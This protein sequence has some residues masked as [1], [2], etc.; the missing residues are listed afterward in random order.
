M[1]KNTGPFLTALLLTCLVLS[2]LI[3][4][5]QNASKPMLR[6]R[7]Q[8]LGPGA[9]AAAPSDMD[10][11]AD[12]LEYRGGVM[13]GSGNLVIRRG[14]EVLT[15]DFGTYNAETGDTS[16]RGN[17]HYE[18]PLSGQQFDGDELK[19]NFKTQQWDFGF[20]EIRQ[21]VFTVFSETSEVIEPGLQRFDNAMVTTCDPANPEFY[22]RA[23]EAFVY[24][25]TIVRAKNAVFYLN[26]LPFLYLP[27]YT[28]DMERDTTNFDFLPGYSSRHGAYVLTA[29]SYPIFDLWATTRLDY[30][31]DRGIGIGEDLAWKDE[32]Y[33]GKLRT[34]FINDDAP[35]KTPEQE[36]RQRADFL[37][38]PDSRY[39]VRLSH[40]QAVSPNDLLFVEA[41][42][43]SD[44]EVTLDFF[45]EE[46]RVMPV[47]E[48]RVSY[49]HSDDYFTAGVELHKNLNDE[50]FSS[51]DRLPEA[52]LSVPRLKIA[53]S[54]FYYEGFHAA[55]LL[56][57]VFNERDQARG[58]TNYDSQ[59]IHTENAV[60]YP[61]RHM[62]F[63]NLIPRI[64]FTGTFYGDTFEQ[65]DVSS[66][67]SATNSLG[68]LVNSTNT[69]TEFVNQGADFRDLFQI[70][71]ET[72][73]KA[74]RVMHNDPTTMGVGLRHVV[75]PFANYTY[76]SEPDLRPPNIP[77]FDNID[78]LDRRHD[79]QFGVRNKWQTKRPVVRPD[80]LNNGKM[81]SYN[82]LVD[83]VDV[84]VSTAYLLD[85]EIDEN[86]LGD[87]LFDGEFRPTDYL[88][89]D[90]RA[91]YNVDASDFSRINTEVQF[92]ADDRSHVAFDH[93]Y[94][95]DRN[96]VLQAEYALWPQ[97][98]VSLEGYSRYEIDRGEFEEQVILV[99]YKTDCVGYGFG[100]RWI[101]G[102]ALL[103][104][105]NAADEDEWQVWGQ[106]WLT[107]F[108][109]GIVELGR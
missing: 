85:P 52:S 2:P 32:N 3:G 89:I 57:A 88:Q 20:S 91:F 103:A 105:G 51:I 11:N 30:R 96:H 5:A 6:G 46:Y 21:D 27:R 19:G 40:Y 60:Y 98:T 80:P 33:A 61:T 14:S 82:Q 104:D 23:R 53:N 22:I 108:P 25:G 100:G 64:G 47:Q 65:K 41:G 58:R 45:D 59:R 12:K 24:D 109:Q 77:Q 95:P 55:G 66:G 92:F 17:V 94:R 107:A 1:Q 36:E 8:A 90:T 72:S 37:D 10:I 28:V 106:I 67:S 76:M 69:T 50:F 75:E 29:Y 48:N 9:P 99:T 54:P 15:A 4:L 13:V 18:N 87:I 68:V 38:I 56:D 78:R 97:A 31:S 62:G 35:Y 63:L 74:F 39:R 43:L 83:L 49:I 84:S 93:F 79:I 16:A 34:Y 44:P 86:E 26:N 7:P 81:E 102:D 70:G 42:K 101:A 73:F 71:F